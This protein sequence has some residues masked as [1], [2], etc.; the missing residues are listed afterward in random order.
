M[1]TSER[2]VRPRL[3][4]LED[5]AVPASNLNQFAVGADAGFAPYVSTYNADGSVHLQFSAYDSLFHGGVHVAMGKVNG[6]AIPDLVTG[7]GPGGGPHVRVFDVPTP[8]PLSLIPYTH[9]VVGEFFAYDATV[10]VGVSV[11]A[12][13]WSARDDGYDDLVTAPGRGAGAHV[14]LFHQ[15]EDELRPFFEFFADNSTTSGLTVGFGGFVPQ[16]GRQMLFVGYGAGLVFTQE[17]GPADKRLLGYGW[18]GTHFYGVR[19]QLQPAFTHESTVGL[20]INT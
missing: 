20:V 9:K 16:R 1:L 15:Y 17:L 11:A 10:T 4:A 14:R 12:G 6:D 13:N 3:L 18:D 19:P 2:R 5:R 8:D 7:P